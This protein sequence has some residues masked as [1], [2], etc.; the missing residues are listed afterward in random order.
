MPVPKG[1][2]RKRPRTRIARST[3]DQPVQ[4]QES[5]ASPAKTSRTARRARRQP[6]LWVNA[7]LGV[8]MIV[9]GVYFTLFSPGGL[10]TPAR[11]ILLVGYV[12]ISGYYFF[13]AYRQYRQRAAL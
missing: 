12:A 11:L 7:G 2:R 3:V 1:K 10:S 4:T 13:K 9:A 5:G 8:L 6:P